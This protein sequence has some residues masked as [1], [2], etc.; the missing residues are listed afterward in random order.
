MI[1]QPQKAQRIISKKPVRFKTWY[2]KTIEVPSRE[3]QI[4]TQTR[5]D[6]RAKTLR[7]F[8]DKLE[9]LIPNIE[10]PHTCHFCGSQK[11]NYHLDCKCEFGI[12]MKELRAE[13]KKLAK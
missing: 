11:K 8:I 13:L 9:H 12:Y 1:T 6:E 7:E 3:E 5:Q 10:R 4:E 2:G